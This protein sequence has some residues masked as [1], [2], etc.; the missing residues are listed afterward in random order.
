MKCVIVS[1]ANVLR[2]LD[3]FIPLVL[4]YLKFVQGILLLMLGPLIGMSFLSTPMVAAHTYVS[5]R[6]VQFERVWPVYTCRNTLCYM[7]TTSSLSLFVAPQRSA[8]LSPP[9]PLY[10]FFIYPERLL[11]NLEPL[12]NVDNFKKKYLLDKHSGSILRSNKV[13]GGTVT[14]QYLKPHESVTEGPS[15]ISS[16]IYSVVSRRLWVSFGCSSC[17]PMPARKL[18]RSA[19]TF[20]RSVR[21]LSL[22]RSFIV[23]SPV[24]E[25]VRAWPPLLLDAYCAP[26]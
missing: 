1:V 4:S 6:W 10:I 25:L 14:F 23:S 8:I 20:I 15:L 24:D 2:I 9:L 16:S 5:S 7:P 13:R 17:A 19:L 3:F 22:M 26:W 21:V 11:Y 18:L 12:A